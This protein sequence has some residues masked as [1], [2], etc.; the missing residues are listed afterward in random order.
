M[1]MLN[2]NIHI[3]NIHNQGDYLDLTMR[4]RLKYQNMNLTECIPIKEIL[5]E[6]L[7]SMMLR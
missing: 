7:V 5:R 3:L 6:V 4:V 1:N 2:M